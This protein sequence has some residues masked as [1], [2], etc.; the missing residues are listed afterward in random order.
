MQYQDLHVHTTLSDGQMSY[1]Q[2]LDRAKQ[3]GVGTVAFTDHDLVPPKDRLKEL[4]SLRGHQTAWI[5]GVELSC[6]P[7]AEL[8]ERQVGQLHIVGLFVDP[9][10][11]PL[12]S[13]GE[14]IVKGRRERMKKVVANLKEVGF[15]ISMKDCLKEVEGEVL[16]RPHLVAAILKKE[17]NVELVKYLFGELEKAAKKDP[18]RWGRLFEQTKKQQ[19]AEPDCPWRQPVYSLLLGNKAFV[20]GV[21]MAKQ[22]VPEMDE[23]VRLIREAGGV[24]IL[25]HWSECKDE[26]PIELVEKIMKEGRIDGAEVVYDLYRIGMGEEKE[27]REE[28]GKVDK[29]VERYGLLKSGGSDAH[30]LERMGE[31]VETVW[32]AKET[33]GLVE[34]ML[35]EKG[36]CRT[37]STVK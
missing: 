21:Y 2:V 8:M 36:L 20:P 26:F 32:F 30:S 18:V 3:L 37:W 22:E 10:Y 15:E 28:Q 1:K 27:L 14:K 6:A 4:G 23:G 13:W 31:M 12:V 33:C 29:L 35:K 16:Q 9:E 34:R 5:V 25:A 17:K 7:P 11:P 24:A 19:E